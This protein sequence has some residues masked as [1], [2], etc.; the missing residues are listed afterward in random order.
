MTSLNFFYS[1]GPLCHSFFYCLILITVVTKSLTRPPED[2][3]VI[4]KHIITL[5]LGQNFTTLR[6]CSKGVLT[7]TQ[8]Q[9]ADKTFESEKQE[10]ELSWVCLIVCIKS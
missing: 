8:I 1:F 3:D 5:L 9:K 7:G 2:Y 4:Y 10:W 6:S